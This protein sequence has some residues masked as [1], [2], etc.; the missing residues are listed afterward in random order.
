MVPNNCYEYS[1]FN[2]DSTRFRYAQDALI[3]FCFTRVS[4]DIQIRPLINDIKCATASAD[5]VTLCHSATVINIRIFDLKPLPTFLHNVIMHISKKKMSGLLSLSSSELE[6][7]ITTI[8]T[9]PFVVILSQTKELVMRILEM[10]LRFY[11]YMIPSFKID[12][13]RSSQSPNQGMP[14]LGPNIPF[15]ILWLCEE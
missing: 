13:I 3:T 1:Q 2:F 4:Y 5:C 9:G 11:T 6:I 7:T 8:P 14:V 10:I 15:L 12:G